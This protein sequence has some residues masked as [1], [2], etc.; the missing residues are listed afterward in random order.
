MA[1]AGFPGGLAGGGERRGGDGEGGGPRLRGHARRA[2]PKTRDDFYFT[3]RISERL[4]PVSVPRYRLGY[5][6]TT[7]SLGEAVSPTNA[8]T[9]YSLTGNC[10]YVLRDGGTNAVLLAGRV[11]GFTSWSASGTVVASDAAEEDAHR[12]LMAILADNLVT[13]LTAQASTLPQ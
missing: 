7:D 13:R 12:R 8:T 1:G 3:R 11:A 5:T 4:D 10:D 6:I 2:A 9:R